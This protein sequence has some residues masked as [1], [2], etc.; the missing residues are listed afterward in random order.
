MNALLEYF[1]KR[2]KINT[3]AQNIH[4]DQ[5]RKSATTATASQDQ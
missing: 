5:H 2:K 3:N 4:M 1:C